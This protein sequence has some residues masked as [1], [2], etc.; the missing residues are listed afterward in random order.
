MASRVTTVATYARGDSTRSPDSSVRWR[1]RRP[2][3]T[4]S[5]ASLTLPSI[6]YAIANAG[7][8]SSSNRS[9]LAMAQPS[10]FAKPSRQLG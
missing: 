9:V 5:S 7:G 2:S 3:C 6:R 4:T 8:R 10:P 1:R